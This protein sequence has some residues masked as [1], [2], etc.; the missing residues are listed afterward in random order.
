MRSSLVTTVSSITSIYI[1]KTPNKNQVYR[2][3]QQE[4]IGVPPLVGIP[5]SD[6]PLRLRK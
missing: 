4:R 2:I 5:I 3:L 6:C 1:T